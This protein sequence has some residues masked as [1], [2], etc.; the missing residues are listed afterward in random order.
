MMVVGEGKK[1]VSALIVPAFPAL[2][3]WAKEHGVTFS[4]NED[5][6]KNPKTLA[7][8]QQVMDENN[9]NFSHIEQIKKFTLLPNEWT[10]ETKEL[11]PTMKIKR[12][13][14]S[15]KYAKEVAAIYGE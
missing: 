2:H 1:F 3:E 4:S 11:T 12:K 15:E 10:T 9:P 6:I 5:L 14:I 8:Y 7:L 13:V